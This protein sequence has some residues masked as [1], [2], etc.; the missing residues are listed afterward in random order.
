MSKLKNLLIANGIG[1]R[2]LPNNSIQV[3]RDVVSFDLRNDVNKLGYSIYML[4]ATAI[5]HK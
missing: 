5:I 3:G 4:D 2:M 1:Y